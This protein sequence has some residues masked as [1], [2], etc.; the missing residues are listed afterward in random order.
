MVKDVAS[1]KDAINW[2]AQQGYRQ[3]KLYNSIRP[4]W[5]TPIAEYAHARGMRVSG[6]IPAF[7]RAEEAVRAGFDEI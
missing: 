7:M 4:E 1:A 6:H 3:I 5:V 2:Y